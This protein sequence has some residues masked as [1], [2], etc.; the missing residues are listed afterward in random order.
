MKKE[1]FVARNLEGRWEKYVTTKLLRVLKRANY[2][3]YAL[4][5]SGCDY[6]FKLPK[7]LIVIG[8]LIIVES[9]ISRL[10][11]KLFVK[12]NLILNNSQIK[13]LPNNLTV[14]G[15]IEISKN[16]RLLPNNH[17]VIITNRKKEDFPFARYPI[18]L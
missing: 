4:N 10:P 14:W 17:K 9:L 7:E 11:D 16:M 13:N 18:I 12:N 3:V 15:N 2:V 5:L 1:I 8:N 6:D